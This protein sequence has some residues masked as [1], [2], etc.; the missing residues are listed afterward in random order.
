M[1]VSD[2]LEFPVVALPK[3]EHVPS[4]DEDE[5]EAARVFYVAATRATQRLVIT[6]SGSAQFGHTPLDRFCDAAASACY[7]ARTTRSDLP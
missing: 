2:G 7:S 5:Q 3:V 1:E 6:A 4:Q